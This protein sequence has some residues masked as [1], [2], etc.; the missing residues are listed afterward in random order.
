LQE[1][2]TNI[3]RH[4][5]SRS[6]EVTFKADGANVVL[7]VRDYGT[8]ISPA[9]LEQFR[10]SGGTGVGL[11]GM[12]ERIHEVGGSLDIDS[13]GKGTC[14]TATLPQSNRAAFAASS[15]RAS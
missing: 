5:G 14:V 8:G 15:D 11:A 10:A 4:S 6:A 12:R 13:S 2:L 9:T 7:A 3:H 1:A